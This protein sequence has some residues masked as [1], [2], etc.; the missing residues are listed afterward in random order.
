MSSFPEKKQ[1][2]TNAAFLKL[3]FLQI[4]EP[5]QF[6]KKTLDLKFPGRASET[7]NQN[8]V[9]FQIL[10][11]PFWVL[12]HLRAIRVIFKFHG[13]FSRVARTRPREGRVRTHFPALNRLCT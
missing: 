4:D 2:V 12:W 6:S 7:H 10:P 3:L 11:S 8:T 1:D 13:F 5:S 9:R